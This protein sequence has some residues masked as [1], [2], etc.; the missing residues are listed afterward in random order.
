MI[1]RAESHFGKYFVIAV[2]YLQASKVEGSDAVV[3]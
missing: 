3:R 2:A 1:L